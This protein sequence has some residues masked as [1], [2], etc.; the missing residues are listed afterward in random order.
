MIQFGTGGWRAVI[1]SDFIESNIC[2][3]AEGIC[4]LMEEEGKTSKPTAIGYDH[5][6]LSESAA[7]W[8]AEV[9]AA[10]NLVCASGFDVVL[11][12]IAPEELTAELVAERILCFTEAAKRERDRILPSLAEAEKLSNEELRAALPNYCPIF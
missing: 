8:M 9:F 10:G 12:G 3:V 2:T 6:F 7:R 1:G 5:R 11:K 4:R